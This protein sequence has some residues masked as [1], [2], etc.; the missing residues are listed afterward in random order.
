MIADPQ[1]DFDTQVEN[2]WSKLLILNK[3]VFQLLS[4]MYINHSFFLF[5]L[6]K[7]FISNIEGS[8]LTSSLYENWLTIP[9]ERTLAGKISAIQR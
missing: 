1:K 9:D 5:P 2:H 6:K 4:Q 3:K 8:L 7:D